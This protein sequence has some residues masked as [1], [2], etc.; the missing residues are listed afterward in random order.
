[1]RN[2]TL[3][4]QITKKSELLSSEIDGEI[5]M[6]NINT[7]KYLSMNAVGSEIW[8]M[9][10]GNPITIETICENLLQMFKVDKA[11]CEREAM[12]FCSHLLKENLIEIN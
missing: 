3:S 11:I 1:M 4:S 9:I 6:M 5:V 12:E 8:K 2:I 10:E 7:G